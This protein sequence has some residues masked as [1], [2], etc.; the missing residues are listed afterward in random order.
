MTRRS[1]ALTTGGAALA[2]ALF[3]A[4][5]AAAD[6]LNNPL[7][8]TTC[9]YA[10]IEAAARV[11]APKFAERLATKPEAQ[12]K[13]QEFLALPVDQRRAKMQARIDANPELAQKIEAK[14]ASPEGQARLQTM[15]R[16][17]DTCSTY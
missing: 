13:I 8:D 2:G 4:P 16:V 9:T 1:W 10:Q 3:A 12:A 11:E 6:P 7:L 17:A 15:Q 14:K 5:S